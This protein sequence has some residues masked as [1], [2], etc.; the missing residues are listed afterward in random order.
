MA[1]KKN[2]DT[3]I[4]SKTMRNEKID[5]VTDEIAAQEF[6]MAGEDWEVFD[7][8]N[9]FRFIRYIKITDSCH[10]LITNITRLMQELPS[11]VTI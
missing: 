7:Q 6:T 11:L 9:F 10:T 3:K 4:I 5:L 1:S 8:D 2:D